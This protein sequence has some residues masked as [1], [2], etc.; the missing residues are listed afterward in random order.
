MP[1]RRGNPGQRAAAIIRKGIADGRFDAS[2]WGH[3][4][5]TGMDSPRWAASFYWRGI[6]GEPQWVQDLYCR[7]YKATHRTEIARLW[8]GQP[9][10]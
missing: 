4:I 8:A 9:S 2:L 3:P 10:A 6:G 5:A 1:K 7:S